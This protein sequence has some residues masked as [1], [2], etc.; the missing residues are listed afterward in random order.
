MT[1]T[2]ESTLREVALEVCT[3]LD[4]AKTTAVLTGG[5]AATIYVPE[6]IQS[7]DLDFV[8]TLGGTGGAPLRALEDLGYTRTD[9]HY[10]HKENRLLLEFPAGPLAIG[11]EL[12]ENWD[13][14]R[15]R[16]KLLNIL[17]PTDSCRDRL[18]AFYFFD[19][20]SALEVAV[21]IQA[22]HP[23]RVDLERIREWSKQEDAEPKFQEFARRVGR[24]LL[25]E[26]N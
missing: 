7:F 17:T 18:S 13:T 25:G 9:F 1:I 14:V 5:G 16:G 8:L 26:A 11:G 15:E 4:Q 20:R 19:D 12:I 6:A 22:A 21:A 10:S 3:A 23:D 24:R 2:R